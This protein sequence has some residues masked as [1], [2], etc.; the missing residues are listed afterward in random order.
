MPELP[1]QQ[2]GQADQPAP[3]EQQPQATETRKQFSDE[4]L[5]KFVG[6]DDEQIS[7]LGI[8]AEVA[9]AR[10]RGV[11]PAASDEDEDG[12]E[13]PAAG[14]SPQLPHAQSER[15]P[16]QNDPRQQQG[17][18]PPAVIQAERQR[19]QESERALAELRQQ[20]LAQQ[21]MLQALLAG[22][23]LGGQGQPAPAEQ[24]PPPDPMAEFEAKRSDLDRRYDDGE[25]PFGE[26]QKQTRAL[27]REER[28]LEQEGLQRQLTPPQRQTSESLALADETRRLSEANPWIEDVPDHALAKI[29]ALAE[30]EL[31]VMGRPPIGELGSL[32]LRRHVIQTAR[33]FG[34]GPPDQPTTPQPSQP[35]P[36]AAPGITA[37]QRAA[38]LALGSTHPPDLSTLPRSN[39]AAPGD[40]TIG[41]LAR[42]SRDQIRALPKATKDRLGAAHGVE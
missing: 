17:N 3:N 11:Q 35:N 24:A 7:E 10:A 25:I 16:E 40:L 13:A 32:E 4:Q 23:N 26:Y 37:Q 20:M 41:D 15:Q 29:A 39:G 1:Q 42:M 2:Q 14:G 12:E 28:R 6:L 31:H 19:R 36:A 18:I 9:A 8:T 22:K 33:R 21:Q 30:H 5:A 38:K 34:Y 27:D